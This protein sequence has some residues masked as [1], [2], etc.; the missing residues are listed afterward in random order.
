MVPNSEVSIVA[1]TSLH[2][3]LPSP[4]T[5]TVHFDSVAILVE[6][7]SALLP[8]RNKFTYGLAL[9]RP[10]RVWY[11]KL[12]LQGVILGLLRISIVFNP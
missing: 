7:V 5:S 2:T 8:S 10:E 12:R 6:E 11:I 9:S 1:V 3:A 4:V